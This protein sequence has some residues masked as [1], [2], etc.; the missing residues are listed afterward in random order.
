LSA[1][2]SLRQLLDSLSREQRRN[3]ELLASLAFALR[4]FTNLGRFLEL[5]PLVAARLVEA[6]GAVLVVFHEDGRLWREY[7]QA[8]PAEP[9]AELVRQL[10]ALAD[11]DLAALSGDA[12][13]APLRPPHPGGA[14]R[15]GARARPRAHRAGAGVCR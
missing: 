13:V 10:A 12:A 11:G 4:S 8:T 14:R 5:V 2:A 9:C 7:L 6:E 1:A 3:Q 15:P